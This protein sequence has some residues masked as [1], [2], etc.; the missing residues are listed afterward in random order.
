M[1]ARTAS[2]GF[3]ANNLPARSTYLKHFN[4]QDM[5]MSLNC[6][7]HP[8]P[9]FQELLEMARLAPNRDEGSRAKCLEHYRK[10]DEGRKEL[11]R[12]LRS[13]RVTLESHIGIKLTPASSAG[14]D[15]AD[16]DQAS[17]DIDF[18]TPWTPETE[19][20]VRRHCPHPPERRGN[21]PLD[22]LAFPFEYEGTPVEVKLHRRVS[23][24]TCLHARIVASPEEEKAVIVYWKTHLA[25]E[26]RRQFKLS[27]YNYYAELAGIEYRF[28]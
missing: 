26:A 8:T 28:E 5:A 3:E 21:P 10:G 13:A 23:E 4:P 7:P 19:A 24:L 12:R 11:K 6:G 9:T 1:R 2:K 16:P 27:V 25:G 22:H 15:T 20:L 18:V 14:D 17:T